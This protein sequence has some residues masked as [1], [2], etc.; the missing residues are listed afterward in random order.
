MRKAKRILRDLKY[1]LKGTK[2]I[3]GTYDSSNMKETKNLDMSVLD[4]VRALASY[5]IDFKALYGVDFDD[6]IYEDAQGN[7]LSM[8]TD[9]NCDN[10]YNWNSQIV[11]AFN[12]VKVVDKHGYTREYVAVMFH[13]Y[14]DVRGNYTDYMV[15]AMSL[16]EFYEILLE[17]TSIGCTINYKGKEYFIS[18]DCFKEACLFD[19]DPCSEGDSYYD[20]CLDIDNYRNKKDIKKALAK[21]LQEV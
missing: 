5:E 4:V 6:A 8:D 18:T 12:S 2:T 21:Y 13:R 16:E 7:Y 1:G 15:L 10:S 17:A 19:I 9:E 3:F 14:G 20:V 11:F